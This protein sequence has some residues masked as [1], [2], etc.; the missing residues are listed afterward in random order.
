M[1]ELKQFCLGK[2]LELRFENSYIELFS[3]DGS[4]LEDRTE[5]SKA[6]KT[7]V[8]E[9][10]HGVTNYGL[11]EGMSNPIIRIFVDTAVDPMYRTF[12]TIPH[13]IQHA[14]GTGVLRRAIVDFKMT[15]IS[16]GCETMARIAGML[17][18]HFQ[19]A[20]MKEVGFVVI[21]EAS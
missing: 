2:Y 16:P 7:L 10:K 13:E 11:W 4:S 1:Q 8:P 6:I 19:Q 20:Y 5:V 18:H 15:E 14:L 3:Y 17:T 12:V 21:K 9:D